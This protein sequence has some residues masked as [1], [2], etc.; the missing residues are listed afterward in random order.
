MEPRRCGA[1]TKSGQKCKQVLK[2]GDEKCWMHSGAQCAVCLS[3]MSTNASTRILGCSHE[4]HERCLDRWKLSCTGP[5]PTCPMCREPFDI[6]LYR[7]RLMIERVS[8]HQDYTRDFET[9]NITSIID[10]F[11]IDLRQLLPP[12]S[13][14]RVIADIHFDIEPGEDLEEALRELGLPMI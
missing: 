9:S 6:P 13:E 12:S 10:G 3:S 2:I 1:E 5:D 7:C 4:F 14:G 11:G 8:N